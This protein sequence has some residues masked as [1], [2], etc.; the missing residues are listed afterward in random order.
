MRSEKEGG[1]AKKKRKE[2]TNQQ[3]RP[4]NNN[5]HVLDRKCMLIARLLT[6]AFRIDLVKPREAR[7]GTERGER[8]TDPGIY[9]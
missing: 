8:T 3:I 7:G 5:N 2:E 1:K 6:L 4:K 9:P